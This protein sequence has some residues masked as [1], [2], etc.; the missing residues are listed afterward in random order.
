MVNIP[1]GFSDAYALTAQINAL[2]NK[3]SGQAGATSEGGLNPD[4]FLLSMQQNFNQILNN[5]ISSS[6][7]DKN[8]NNP[9]DIFSSMMPGSKAN[10]QIIPLGQYVA[11]SKMAADKAVMELGDNF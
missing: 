4:E 7:D 8:K 2:K 6:D 9:S 3:S 11:A 1:S 5:F 10:A